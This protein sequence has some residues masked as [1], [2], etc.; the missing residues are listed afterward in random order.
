MIRG[1]LSHTDNNC[2]TYFVL[3]GAITKQAIRDARVARRK[4]VDD[5]DIMTAADWLL[6]FVEGSRYE[7][8][9]TRLLRLEGDSSCAPN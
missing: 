9:I 6:D 3:L 2:D 5:A 8:G 4:P 1:K 7:N